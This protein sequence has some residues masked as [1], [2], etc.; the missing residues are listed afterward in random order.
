MTLFQGLYRA[1][2]WL[3][4]PLLGMMLAGLVYYFDVHNQISH[5]YR[6]LCYVASNL[7]NVAGF[8]GAM[9]KLAKIESEI[10]ASRED[11]SN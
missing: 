2:L 3:S 7:L 4:L 5:F 10:K 9:A 8:A 1:Q 11:A 6:F